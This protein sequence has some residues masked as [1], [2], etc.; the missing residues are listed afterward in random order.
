MTGGQPGVTNGGASSETVGC[1]Q[2]GRGR[3][4]SQVHNWPIISPGKEGS[5]AQRVSSPRCSPRPRAVVVV[6]GGG[7]FGAGL[8]LSQSPVSDGPDTIIYQSG[9]PLN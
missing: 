2:G 9:S 8:P 3:G 7:Q 6:V 4:G 5:Q 1:V